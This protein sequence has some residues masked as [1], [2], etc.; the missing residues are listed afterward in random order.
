MND[1]LARSSDVS[2]LLKNI[3]RC[4]DKSTWYSDVATAYSRT[5]PRYPKQII[6]RVREI[7]KLQPGKTI[8]EIGSGPGIATEELA[9]L[10]ADLTCIEPSLSALQLAQSKCATYSNV[11]FI[12]ATFEDWE[13]KP[14]KFDAVIATT[15]FHWLTP[16]IRTEK[17]ASALKK[18]GLLI[19]LWNTPPQSSY[20]S[21]QTLTRAY[22]TH[23]P[24]LAKY[25]S[26]ANH[27]QNLAQ[28]GQEVIDSGYFQ[29][30]IEEQLITQVTYSVDDYLTLLSTLSPYIRLKP[31]TRES[32]LAE[33]KEILQSHHG[34]RLELSY[35][36]MMQI[37][38]KK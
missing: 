2:R 29:D 14:E 16:G 4:A 1:F 11:K 6:N 28:L 13:L 32:L 23:A 30:L 25:E 37:A 27:Q 22:Q 24:N 8:L 7:A 34:D 21:H 38:R 5:R 18:E 12:N 3:Y 35:L 20:A 19:L 17:T 9:K 36:S 26:L 31:A 10:G 33:L 15:A